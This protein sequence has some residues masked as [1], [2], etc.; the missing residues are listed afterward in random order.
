M[1]YRTQRQLTAWRELR[2]TASDLEAASLENP[3]QYVTAI[4]AAAQCYS[5]LSPGVRSFSPRCPPWP[6]RW[7]PPPPWAKRSTH[8]ASTHCANLE[9]AMSDCLH[10]LRTTA[11]TIARQRRHWNAFRSTLLPHSDFLPITTLVHI[12]TA[13]HPVLPKLAEGLIVFPTG[14]SI[15]TRRVSK[16]LLALTSVAVRE[17]CLALADDARLSCLSQP[18]VYCILNSHRHFRITKG[19]VHL[20][21]NSKPLSSLTPA[22]Q[23]ALRILQDNHGIVDREYYL[24][25][26]TDADFGQ[27][28]ATAVLRSPFIVR[29]ERGIYALRGSVITPDQLQATR[30][31]STNRFRASLLRHRNHADAIVLDYRLSIPSAATGQL[32]LPASHPLQLGNWPVVYPDETSGT[33]QLRATSLRGL[34]P[35]LR[36]ANASVGLRFSLEVDTEARIIYVTLLP[37]RDS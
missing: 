26:M 14:A 34:R 22:Q 5:T 37:M 18:D 9:E 20:A 8:A 17:L 2:R 15:L 4:V 30:H 13:G 25:R 35:W 31:A 6:C 10:H 23:A 3:T 29:L 33:L 21:D 36:R 1:R 11:S 16:V 12:A 28:L 32:P 27:P 19:H 7:G 24:H